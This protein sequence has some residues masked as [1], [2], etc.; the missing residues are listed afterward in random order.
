MNRLALTIVF[1]VGLAPAAWADF[2]AGVAAY[3]RGDYATAL[4]EFKPLAEQ[5]DALAQ[6]NLGVMYD[7]GEGVPQDYVEVLKWNRKAAERGNASAQFKLGVMYDNEEGVAQD[8]A[9]VL[10][11]ALLVSGMPRPLRYRP[12]QAIKFRTIHKHGVPQES[13]PIQR[14]SSSAAPSGSCSTTLPTSSPIS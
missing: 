14:R 13:W 6:F 3:Q 4:R 9:E 5:G 8:D 1:A 7:N 11:C 10:K 2:Q 12:D